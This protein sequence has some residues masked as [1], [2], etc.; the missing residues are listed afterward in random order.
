M[1]R[2]N[3]YGRPVK[4][5][6]RTTEPVFLSWVVAVLAAEG[7]AAMVLDVHASVL[8]GSTH[9]IPRR[10]MVEDGDHVRARSLLAEAGEGDRLADRR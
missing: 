6:L 5:L 10:V 7:I 4:E 8:Q 3:S 2:A 9:A 1:S